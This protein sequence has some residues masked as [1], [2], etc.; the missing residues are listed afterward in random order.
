MPSANPPAPPRFRRD[1][2]YVV[3]MGWPLTRSRTRS[4]S[5]L[6]TTISWSG[7]RLWVVNTS[8]DLASSSGRR[9]VTTT[10]YTM[11]F[12]CGGFTGELL[13]GSGLG[14]HL[15][16]MSC[17]VFTLVGPHDVLDA[18]GQ[19]DDAVV[20]PHR[21]LAQPGQEFVGMAG[22][23]Q[24]SRA[25]DQALQPGLSLLE[26]VCVDGADPLVEKQD[27]RVDAG[28]HAHRQPHPHTGGVGPQRHQQVVAEF[29]ELGDLVDLGQHLPAGLPEEEPADDDVLVAGDLGV[30]A[31]AQIEHRRH[32]T[33]DHRGAARRLIDARKQPEQRRFPGAV[34]AYQPDSVAQVQRHRDVPQRLD[35]HHVGR[36]APDRATQDGLLQRARFGVEDG[37]LHPRVV[38]LYVWT[39]WRHRFVC[40]EVLPGA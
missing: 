26:E 17:G 2:R 30:H 25:L 35:D 29:G 12:I 37:K 20:D 18:A 21:G 5:S 7:G 16:Y 40:L 13:V 36:V 15:T 6:S 19:F 22:E 24:D 8:S 32:P 14:E 38:G 31:D 39:S 28:D 33:A 3:R 34:V 11:S 23:H 9:W 27:L 4:S 1:G 10:A